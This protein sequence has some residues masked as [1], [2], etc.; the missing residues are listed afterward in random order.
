MQTLDVK[1]SDLVGSLYDDFINSNI[2]SVGKVIDGKIV[3]IDTKKGIV[4]VY[5][6][7]KSE[8]VVPIKEFFL[9]GEKENLE[10]GAQTK[11]YVNAIDSKDGKLILSREK[12][13][14]EESWLK[15]KEAFSSGEHIVGIPFAKVK[16]GLS[17]D[18]QGFIAFLPG[19]QID[20][21]PVKD[22][23]NIVGRKH[24]FKVITID[25]NSKSAIV[26]RKAV[27]DDSY[28][29]S[30]D[31]F[32]ANVK[33]G[34]TVEGY[35]K[36]ITDYGV[37]VDL[38]YG[39]DAL[40]HLADITWGKISHPSEVLKIQEH[41]KARVMKSDAVSGKI[42][43]SMK[44][45]TENP[46]SKL[47]GDIQVGK[48]IK[49]KITNIVDYGF[50]VA[51]ADGIEGLVHISEIT[52]SKDYHKVHKAFKV[53]EEVEAVVIEIDLDKQRIAL[54]LRRLS[55]NPWKEFSESHKFGDIIEG[56]IS[57]IADYGIFVSLGEID[58]LI[59]IDDLSWSQTAQIL[60][61][62]KV[63]DHVK[64]MYLSIDEKYT[65]IRLGMKQLQENPFEK[66]AEHLKVGSNVTCTVS[67]I[68]PDRVDI[69]IFDFINSSIKKQDLSRDKSE[70]RVDRFTVNDKIDAKI[71]AYD[72]ATGK[73]TVSVK[74]LEE[75]EY[76]KVLKK[77]GSSDTGAS[78][79]D[80][81][82][83]ALEKTK[84]N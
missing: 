60:T 21:V 20:S 6:G 74:D 33:D 13:I 39:I 19:S 84:N 78:I 4:I 25:E 75:E 63:G 52:W 83:V 36:N 9:N 54:S 56:S 16:G 1:V 66:Y 10:V 8:G 80:I 55:K 64:A 24:V 76:A 72:Q 34:D 28:K 2:N 12:A 27:F 61:N 81:L 18:F 43:L 37:F 23:S 3:F 62:Y 73:I 32:F 41:V 79:A 42:S 5:A 57:K 30:R 49:C 69:L 15:I 26:S 7:L 17:V 38:G 53:D 47:I 58:G 68:K 14:R 77:Y 59:H 70:Q 71:I 31:A 46:W 51:I 29:T 45:L 82:G 40:L 44:H 22:I 50:F 48:I 67:S 35:V 65:K 11:V